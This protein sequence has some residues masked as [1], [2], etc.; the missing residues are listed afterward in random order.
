MR[1]DIHQIEYPDSG[2]LAC[3]VKQH[4]LHLPCY[5]YRAVPN[6]PNYFLGP[7]TG[8]ICDSLT[9]GINEFFPDEN[10]AISPN[11]ATNLITIN[12]QHVK[13]KNAVIYIYTITGEEI[14]HAK[15]AIHDGYITQDVFIGTYSKSVYIVK[16]QTDAG[17]ATVKFVKQ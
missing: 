10:L 1:I 2:G 15:L 5:S 7:V 12:A 3:N 6:H 16:M 9:I 14:Y 17:I 11:P 13:G 8:S 4:Y